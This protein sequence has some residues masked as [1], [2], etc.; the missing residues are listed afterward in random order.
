LAQ[1]HLQAQVQAMMQLQAHGPFPPPAAI[2]EYEAILPGTF[3]RIVR[4]AEKAQQ[5]QTD[6]V[7]SGQQALRQ[8][9][10]RV[11]WMAAAISVAAMVGAGF[12]ASIHETWVACAFLG[13]PV[14]AVAKAFIDSLKAPNANQQAQLLQQVQQQQAEQQ[15]QILQQ[16]AEKAKGE[17]GKE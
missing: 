5:D 17:G 7:R 4:M 14:F 6:T 2:R 8:D 1:Q 11:H 3:E 9:T 10:R 12:C 15:R 13:V 16:I